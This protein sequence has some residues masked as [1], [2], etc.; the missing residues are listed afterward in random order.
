MEKEMMINGIEFPRYSEKIE[1]VKYFC[2]MDLA[3]ERDITIFSVAVAYKDDDGNICFEFLKQMRHEKGQEFE[4]A[5]DFYYKKLTKHY[6]SISFKPVP[7]RR[8]ND[9][10]HTLEEGLIEGKIKLI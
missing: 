6:N 9:L 8:L 5:V 4:Q 2:G 3:D 1:G 7:K 10:A